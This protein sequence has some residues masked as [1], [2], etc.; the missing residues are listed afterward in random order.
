V[1][2]NLLGTDVGGLLDVRKEVTLMRV[3]LSIRSVPSDVLFLR[4]EHAVEA[5][6]GWMPKTFLDGGTSA[7]LGLH[8]G[9]VTPAGLNVQ[10]P[11]I[12]LAGSLDC[13][14]TG[15]SVTIQVRGYLAYR[16][17]IVFR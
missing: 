7:A 13:D 9:T 14:E 11:G 15:T 8:E 2:A 1:L 16:I 12:Q 17:R 6:C 4:Q 5:G 10:L 3:L